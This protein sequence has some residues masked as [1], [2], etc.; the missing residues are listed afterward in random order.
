MADPQSPEDRLQAIEARLRFLEDEREIRQLICSY[1]PAVDSGDSTA[2]AE[3][4]TDDGI[5]DYTTIID[6]HTRDQ[7]LDKQGIHDMLELSHHQRLIHEGAAHTLGPAHIEID[8]DT[9]VATNY[10]VILRRIGMSVTIYRMAGNRWDLV[11][12]ANGWRTKRRTT[13]M[14]DGSAEARE[15][16]GRA[17]HD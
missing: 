9:A 2:A 12:T 14:L 1:G 6:D 5:Y 11:R 4:W 17:V 13:R 7:E 3:L 8:G 10:S 16:L 15:L